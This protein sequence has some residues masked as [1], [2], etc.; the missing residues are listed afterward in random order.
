MYDETYADEI[1][2]YFDCYNGHSK[3]KIILLKAKFYSE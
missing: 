3:I 2:L 1:I